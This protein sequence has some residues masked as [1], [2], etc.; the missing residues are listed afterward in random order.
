MRAQGKTKP[1]NGF[2]TVQFNGLEIKH[3]FSIRYIINI[4]MMVNMTKVQRGKSI[5]SA[6]R[7]TSS[8]ETTV[9]FADF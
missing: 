1:I 9:R 7:E 4:G 8:T 2:V 5:F 6:E 3:V